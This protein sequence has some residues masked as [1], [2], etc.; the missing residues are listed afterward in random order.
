[1]SA[2]SSTGRTVW[3]A[4]AV[5]GTLD[6]ADA[7]LFSKWRGT[8][9]ERVLQYIAS[10]LIGKSA[11]RGG[12]S[13]AALGLAIHYA[14][15]LG[16]VVLFVVAVRRFSETR[17]AVIAGVCYGL[18]MYAV[19]NVLVLPHTKLG[20]RA[21]PQGLSLVNGVVALVLCFGVPLALI[22]KRSLR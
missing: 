15:A 9:P 21:F 10:A 3:L 20:P 14:I 16:W 19:M 7:L 2:G 1:M 11:F 12:W 22:C 17:H 18:L 4:T 8:G 5:C 6:L 13:T